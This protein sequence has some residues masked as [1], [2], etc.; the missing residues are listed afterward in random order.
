MMLENGSGEALTPSRM[1]AFSPWVI[2]FSENLALP[3]G[4]TGPWDFAPLA[5]GRRAGLRKSASFYGIYGTY[6]LPDLRINHSDL[7]LEGYPV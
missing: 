1:P 7:D 3:S 6:S 2:A 4:V 5:R